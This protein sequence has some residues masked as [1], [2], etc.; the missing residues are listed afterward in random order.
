MAR[1]PVSP[2]APAA[3]EV[4]TDPRLLVDDTPAPVV[5]DGPAMRVMVR[6]DD[7]ATFDAVALRVGVKRHQDPGS[8][9]VVDEETGEVIRP[10]VEPSGPLVPVRGVTIAE[11]GPMVLTPGTYDD[12]GNEL[13]PPVEDSRYHVNFWLPSNLVATDGWQKLVRKWRAA[14][15]AVA[16]RNKNEQAIKADGIELLDPTT[17]ATPR[18]VLL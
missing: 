17:I 18:N 7:K 8:P 11:L 1:K 14:G 12:E 15:T 3:Q 6:A 10:A 2:P 5:M 13:T 4:P 9:E 16:Q